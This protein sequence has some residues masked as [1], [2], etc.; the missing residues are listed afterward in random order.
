ML[1]FPS[2]CNSGQDNEITHIGAAQN[3]N[4]SFSEYLLPYK[5]I[6]TQAVAVNCITV[7]EKQIFREGKP[8][9]STCLYEGLT[10]FL[11]WL[12]AIK[13]PVVLVA[14]NAKFDANV[15]CRSLLTHK[16]NEEAAR[17]IQGFVDTLSLF[18]KSMPGLPSYK[19]QDLVTSIIHTQYSAHD[20]VSDA[21]ALQ[22][23]VNSQKFTEDVLLEHSFSFDS[24]P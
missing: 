9:P 13:K 1:C 10:N 7:A 8:V 11:H 21:K 3:D 12:S 2:C 5:R 18:R 23:L 4:T 22:Q 16:L 20:A 6:S 17:T 14:Q 19:Q 24:S 15:V